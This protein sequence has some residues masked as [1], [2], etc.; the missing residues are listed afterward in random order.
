MNNIIGSNAFSD[1]NK[2]NDYMDNIYTKRINDAEISK[3]DNSFINNN[4]EDIYHFNAMAFDE[5]M[6]KI[7]MNKY[8]RMKQYNESYY[9]NKQFEEDTDKKL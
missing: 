1:N 2:S 3:N 8:N 5:Y 6:S 9:L 7:A 4:N